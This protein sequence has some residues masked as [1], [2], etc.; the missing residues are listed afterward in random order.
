MIEWKD[1]E[2]DSAPGVPPTK[3]GVAEGALVTFV[4]FPGPARWECHCYGIDDDESVLLAQS[5]LPDTLFRYC[6]VILPRVAQMRNMPK[7]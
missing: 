6:D 1:V 4:V 3:M 5:P 7:R 2:C